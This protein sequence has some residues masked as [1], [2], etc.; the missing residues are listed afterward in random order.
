MTGKTKRKSKYAS[1]TA[2]RSEE[3]KRYLSFVRKNYMKPSDWVV[4]DGALVHPGATI[5]VGCHHRGVGYCGGCAARVDFAL[6]FVKVLLQ[7]GLSDD[8][9]K[10]L[11]A[12][13]AARQA[14]RDGPDYCWSQRQ[15][16]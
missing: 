2:T 15:G 12:V 16:A 14:D 6:D 1:P 8:A 4:K 11:N 3:D 9:L 10:M 5:Q 13:D 7:Q